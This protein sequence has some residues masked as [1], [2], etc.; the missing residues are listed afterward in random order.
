MYNRQECYSNE[1]FDLILRLRL[2]FELRIIFTLKDSFHCIEMSLKN[3]VILITGAASG[4]GYG[5]AIQLAQMGG[6]MSL[7][8]LDS[9][10]LNEIA[11]RIE[12][13]FNSSKLLKIVANIT[14]DGQRIVDETIKHFGKL[15]VLVNCAGLF[16]C[17]RFHLR[18]LY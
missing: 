14:T 10:G 5:T 11:K 18:L 9:N 4:I 8:D 2:S 13:E 15:D 6:Q 7:V 1:Q 3:K 17:L 16:G 12:D